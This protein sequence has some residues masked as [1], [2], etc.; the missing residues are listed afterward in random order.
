[1]NLL[2]MKGKQ[3]PLLI[4]M[5]IHTGNNLPVAKMPYTLALKHHD[6]VKSEIDKLFEAG[7]IRERVI[8]AGQLPLLWYQR[9]MVVKGYV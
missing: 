4:K 9:E 5:S 2:K 3:E 1:M 6:W 7:V 8:L